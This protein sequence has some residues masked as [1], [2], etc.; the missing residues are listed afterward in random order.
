[1]AGCTRRAFL[2]A[3]GAGTSAFAAS[4]VLGAGEKPAQ[5]PNIVVILADDLGY[6]DV[7]CY[8]PKGKI[9]TPCADRLAAE[10]VCFT[11]AH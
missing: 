7:G 5:R 2:G 1:M 11:D 4:R 3:I 9:P 6:G 10:G 8:N